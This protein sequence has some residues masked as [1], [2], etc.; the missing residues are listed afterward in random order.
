MPSG[1]G[2]TA[3]PG[4]IW[5]RR[6]DGC[7]IRQPAWPAPREHHGRGRPVPQGRPAPRGGARDEQDHAVSH[8]IPYNGPIPNARQYTRCPAASFE[9]PMSAEFQSSSSCKSRRNW[10]ACGWTAPSRGCFRSIPAPASRAGSRPAQ[11]QVG[12]LPCKPQGQGERG[13][14]CARA[15]VGEPASPS[16]SVRRR[17]FRSRSCTRTPTCW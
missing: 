10:R 12:R 16:A 2:R 17:R 13:S 9:C 15:P 14:A 1:P 8:P 5:R 4:R 11:V 3:L 6:P 7:D